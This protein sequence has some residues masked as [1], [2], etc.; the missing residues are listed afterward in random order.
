ME[1]S[2]MDKSTADIVTYISLAVIVI[3]LASIGVNL[4]GRATDTGIVNITIE[5][6]A[7]INFSRDLIDFGSGRINESVAILQTNGSGARIGGNWTLV[8]NGFNITNIGNQNLTLKITSNESASTLL[9]GSNPLFQYKVDN[10]GDWSGCLNA[11]MSNGTATNET[12][13]NF[14]TTS[15]GDQICNVFGYLDGDDSIEV[16]VYLKFSTDASAGNH[17][18]LITAT[19]TAI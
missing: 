5:S 17:Q 3:S 15:P 7:A 8:A 1:G 2:I 11:S 12:F 6:A 10:T 4:T 19:G 16:D 9:A 13:L 14:N 18:A